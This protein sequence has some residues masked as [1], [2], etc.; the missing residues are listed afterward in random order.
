MGAT[1][2]LP[3]LVGPARAAELLY[4]G[5]VIDGT[6]AAR[7]GLVNEAVAPGTIG[8][9]AAALA[10]EIAASA[11]LAVRGTRRALAHSPT[12]SLEEQLGFEAARQAECYET[13]DLVEGIA[14]IREKRE[15]R[16]RGD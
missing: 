2:T 15:P 8:E 4:T 16:F 3:R 12:A 14:A 9:R 1:W 7:I 5:R 6:E 13:R 11:P 10:R